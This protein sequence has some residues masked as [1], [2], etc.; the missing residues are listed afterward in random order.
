MPIR[1]IGD[2]RFASENI[3]LYEGAYTYYMGVYRPTEESMMR[4]NESPFNAPSR[5]AIYD[6]V[7]ELGEERSVSTIDE[8][9]TFDTQHKPQRWN[10]ATTRS[11]SPWQQRRPAPPI[12][13]YR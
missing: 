13:I 5:K 12:I 8:F 3:G 1:F 4:H 9:A 2:P 6:K 11:L 7:M 10:Y